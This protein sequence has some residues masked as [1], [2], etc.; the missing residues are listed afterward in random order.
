[1]K[2]VPTR[3]RRAFVE[4]FNSHS[5]KRDNRKN[6]PIANGAEYLSKNGAVGD[7]IKPHD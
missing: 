2:T 1:M 4:P 3:Y 6:D 5:S 7:I